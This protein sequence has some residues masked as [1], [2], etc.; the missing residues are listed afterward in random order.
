MDVS[1]LHISNLQSL[2]E[3]V[4]NTLRQAIISGII[5]PGERLS[6]IE[7]ATILK[8]S[9]TP[10]REAFRQL[11]SEGLINTI[12]R[13]GTFVSRISLKDIDE[14]YSVRSVLEGLAVYLAAKNIS[15]EKNNQLLK[16]LHE[17]R[18]AHEN[19][20]SEKYI[21]LSKKFHGTLIE[22]SENS[23]LI[24]IYRTLENQIGT[25][26]KITLSQQTRVNKSLKE[27]E[28]I[29]STIISGRAEKAE[30]L[31]RR[32]IAAAHKLIR[33]KFYTIEHERETHS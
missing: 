14:I 2:R 19:G 24:N 15:Q 22:I 32:H 5:K 8:V 20:D 1:S 21:N 3:Q 29:I 11:E 6:E 27:H 12:P 16:I 10:V 25:F 9:R 13:I 7:V 30:K 23:K 4:A 26:R 31:I 18:L 33:K 28:D 17:M